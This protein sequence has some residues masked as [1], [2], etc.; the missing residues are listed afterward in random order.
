MV[1]Y[2]DANHEWFDIFSVVGNGAHKWE[3][4]NTGFEEAYCQAIGWM[5]LVTHLQKAEIFSFTAIC[6]YF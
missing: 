6:R 4:L 3:V 1:R 5:A 2:M